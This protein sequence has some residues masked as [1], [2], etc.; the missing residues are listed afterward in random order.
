MNSEKQTEGAYTVLICYVSIKP[1]HHGDC[2]YFD[3][4][5]LLPY[6]Q[7]AAYL[8]ISPSTFGNHAYLFDCAMT[9]RT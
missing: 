3:N 8:V 7:L 1:A 9:G 5:W 6:I 2:Y 4:V